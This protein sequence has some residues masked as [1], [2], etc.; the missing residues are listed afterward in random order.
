MI[1]FLFIAIT[2]YITGLTISLSHSLNSQKNQL[3]LMTTSF[4]ATAEVDCHEAK[5]KGISLI[6]IV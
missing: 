5:R 2:I 4:G 3:T 1:I 6:P